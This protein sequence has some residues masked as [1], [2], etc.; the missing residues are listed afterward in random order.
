MAGV[1][2]HRCVLLTMPHLGRI[3]LGAAI[4]FTGIGCV[5]GVFPIILFVVIVLVFVFF[6]VIN[7]PVF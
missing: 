4:G 1:C 7:I 5:C 6:A 2:K 3:V